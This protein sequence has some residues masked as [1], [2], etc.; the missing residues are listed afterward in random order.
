MT[1]S[2]HEST[3]ESPCWTMRSIIPVFGR[4]MG[5]PSGPM[6]NS[7]LPPRNSSLYAIRVASPAEV[8]TIF[9]CF[10]RINYACYEVAFRSG[11]AMRQAVQS[12]RSEQA[13]S[14]HPCPSVRW[15]RRRRCQA[16]LQLEPQH[17][18]VSRR[19]LG[20]FDQFTVDSLKHR[21]FPASP[22]TARKRT[23][24]SSGVTL[25][26]A[27]AVIRVRNFG[28]P[29]SLDP[30]RLA[31]LDEAPDALFPAF[32]RNLLEDLTK[33][34]FAPKCGDFFS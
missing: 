32:L 1:G 18:G 21:A 34:R 27:V 26:M 4:Y 19:L 11:L 24:T 14:R 20:R 16:S 8:K 2:I 22:A 15:L 33:C 28:C 10:S 12:P 23:G 13:G 5:L 29:D 9:G 25:F 31:Q 30:V 17:Q 3:C 7:P 6:T